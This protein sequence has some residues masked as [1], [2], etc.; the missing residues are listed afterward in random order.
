MSVTQGRRP[1]GESPT[2]E[3]SFRET[4]FTINGELPKIA[5][6]HP[7][8][9][10]FFE[11]LQ[12]LTAARVEEIFRGTSLVAFEV[13]E[14]VDLTNA[15]YL[16]IQVAWFEER[17]GACV[18]DIEC[19]FSRRPSPRSPCRLVSRGRSTLRRFQRFT[20]VICPPRRSSHR[21]PWPS[22]RR[23]FS[24]RQQTTLRGDAHGTFQRC[25]TPPSCCSSGRS[26]SGSPR[27]FEKPSNS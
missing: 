25:P 14:T 1:P 11:V 24:P 9:G 3:N 22:P 4:T 5:T 2:C 17:C 21:R 26:S 7:V 8:S 20:F 18:N 23:S 6:P 10:A 19:C 16:R 27:S 13:C 15:A 12:L